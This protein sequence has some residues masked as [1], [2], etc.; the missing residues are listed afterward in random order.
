MPIYNLGRLFAL[1]ALVSGGA[2]M[3]LYDLSRTPA[4][5]LF[6]TSFQEIPVFLVRLA[7]KEACAR[8]LTIDCMSRRQTSFERQHPLRVSSH[9]DAAR[10]QC[11]QEIPLARNKPQPCFRIGDDLEVRLAEQ[12]V[13]DRHLSCPNRHRCLSR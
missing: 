13:L 11:P 4:L 2:V 12:A 7:T 6:E 1:K 8:R 9:P 10:E 3:P 5:N